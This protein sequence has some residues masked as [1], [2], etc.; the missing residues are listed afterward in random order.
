[1]KTLR[2]RIA[3]VNR[4]SKLPVSLFKNSLRDWQAAYLSR[5]AGQAA[6]TSNDLKKTTST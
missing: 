6:L 2:R 3:P 1:M 5:R 4:E